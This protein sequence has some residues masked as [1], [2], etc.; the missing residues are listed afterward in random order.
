MVLNCLGPF[1]EQ[2]APRGFKEEV[3]PKK[4]LGGVKSSG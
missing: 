2:V 3:L 1:K 4:M